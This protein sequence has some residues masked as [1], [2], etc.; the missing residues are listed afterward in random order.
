MRYKDLSPNV[1]LSI[2]SYDSGSI[3]AT[4]RFDDS[5]GDL[6][7]YLFGA[8]FLT[9]TPFAV[10]MNTTFSYLFVPETVKVCVRDNF[11]ERS[12]ALIVTDESEYSNTLIY[13]H[14]ATSLPRIISITKL[15]VMSP[16]VGFGN[17][18]IHLAGPA[19]SISIHLKQ[20]IPG[21]SWSFIEIDQ[22][23]HELPY[24]NPPAD[25]PYTYIRNTLPNTIS[26]EKSFYATKLF[27]HD[28]TVTTVCQLNV[29][30]TG[31]LRGLYVNSQLYLIGTA[32]GLESISIIPQKNITIQPENLLLA[33]IIG[34]KLIIDSMTLLNCNGT[35]HFEELEYNE[36]FPLITYTTNI[37]PSG[38]CPPTCESCDS[39]QCFKCKEYYY[40][41]KGTCIKLCNSTTGLYPV[42]EQYCGQEP[43][44]SALKVAASTY[45]PITKEVS[46]TYEIDPIK[47]SAAVLTIAYAFN[48]TI[49]TNLPRAC[50]DSDAVPSLVQAAYSLIPVTAYEPST[51]NIKLNLLE[52]AYGDNTGVLISSYHALNDKF[53]L[54]EFEQPPY[55]GEAISK[56]Y[57][58][59]SQFSG[60]NMNPDK[61]Y[62]ASF[63]MSCQITCSLNIKFQGGFAI[64]MNEMTTIF[65]SIRYGPAQW[66]RLSQNFTGITYFSLQGMGSSYFDFFF[67]G[68]HELYAPDYFLFENQI[69]I[70]PNT[71]CDIPNCA[72]CLNNYTCLACME[73]YTLAIT[74]DSCI[75][76]CEDLGL[77]Q[78]NS[79]RRCLCDT[80]PGLFNWATLEPATF[81]YR[82][83]QH[84]DHQLS[85]SSQSVYL[86]TNF[87][88]NDSYIVLITDESVYNGSLV[89][90]Y[91]IRPLPRIFTVKP[92]INLTDWYA[93]VQWEFPGVALTA[94]LSYHIL[95]VEQQDQWNRVDYPDTIFHSFPYLVNPTIVTEGIPSISSCH[96]AAVLLILQYSVEYMHTT[97]L[98]NSLVKLKQTLLVY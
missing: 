50:P 77:K 89:F 2:D 78:I 29:T 35:V 15:A 79:E 21:P 67:D 36:T 13:K 58:T 74:E 55:C 32:T 91:S 49:P 42:H 64:I 16:G 90:S 85:T 93:Y 88:R 53:L 59:Y 57:V 34:Y 97:Q 62:E 43:V 65:D 87:L 98:L 27:S 63:I 17:P 84:C 19:S 69:D 28:A 66:Y 47:L 6:S 39:E 72:N 82:F 68:D 94:N 80:A 70:T 73:G 11:T 46:L 38:G 44:F 22:V 81:D 95:Y 41:Y 92:F 3:Q 52:S 37:Q 76:N 83:S 96:Q 24:N 26:T 33:T 1:S 54:V 7:E 30:F 86:R 48:K 45:D 23:F 31:I 8:V 4:Y 18:P 25:L 75:S 56:E 51:Y 10:E 71:F 9:Y 60:R 20:I 5:D 14:P 61:I 40:L 12:Y